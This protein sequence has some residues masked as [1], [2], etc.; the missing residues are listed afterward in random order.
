MTASLLPANAS[1]L[2]RALEGAGHRDVPAPIARL[3]RPETCPGAALPWLAWA[4][5]VDVWDGQWPERVRRENIADAVRLHRHKGTRWAIERVLE[6][7][8][9]LYDLDELDG[10][11]HHR[12]RIV[13]RNSNRLLTR[14]AK[15]LKG[16]IEA[17]KRASVHYALR[18]EAAVGG[19]LPVGGGLG[20]TAMARPVLHLA[21]APY[22]DAGRET[23]AFAAGMGAAAMAR[24]PGALAID[25]PLAGASVEAAVAA[26]AGAVSL[27]RPLAALRL[28]A[29]LALAPQ[30]L[31]VAA[32]LGASVV[33]AMWMAA[34]LSLTAKDT[35]P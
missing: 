27:A 8:G 15:A 13:I 6:R 16:Q 2:E 24:A 20:A 26:G 9:A 34:D 32:G 7:I 12:I 29:A 22:L 19:A 33:V 14:D 11:D 4:L 28:D 5:S 3:W 31:A 35:P 18:L 1:R 30:A 10:D 21:V 25:A 17:V 23:A